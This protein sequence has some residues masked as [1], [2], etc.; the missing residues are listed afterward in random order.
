MKPR[1]ILKKPEIAFQKQDCRKA[2]HRA[3]AF[4]HGRAAFVQQTFG[5]PRCQTFVPINNR[6]TKLARE[7]RSANSRVYSL[8]RLSSPLICNGLPTSRV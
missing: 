7:T 1:L 8:C 2:V 4:Q 3:S 5:F 6:Q